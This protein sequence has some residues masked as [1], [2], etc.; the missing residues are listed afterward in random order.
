VKNSFLVK[1]R[2]FI[3]RYILF[4][5]LAVFCYLFILVAIRMN[6]TYYNEFAFGKFDLGNMVQMVW[7]TGQGRFMYLTD[8]FG[9]NMPRWG[10]SHVDPIVVLFVPVF[11][12]IPHPLTLV[13][14]QLILIVATS[15]LLY[16]LARRRL[17]TS[18]AGF[19]VA[20]SYMFYPALGF[21][22]TRTSFHGVSVSIFFFVAAFYLF[23]RMYDS[24]KF[25]K[26]G[27]T[28]FW[29]LL[30]ITM[31][32]KEQVPLYTF[33]YGLFLWLYRKKRTLGLWVSGVSLVWFVM[34]FF[35][36]IPAFS[37]YRIEGYERFAQSL[38]LGED[39][40]E[41]V[42]SS[43]YFLTRY[44]AFG[45]SYSEVLINMATRPVLV[46]KEFFKG[47]GRRDFVKTFGPVGF[48][49]FLSPGLV[50]MA[51][52]DLMI[53]YLS[54]TQGIG[55]TSRIDTHRIS[56]IIPVIFIS[57][58]Y[59]VKFL[60]DKLSS[61]QK[62]V[63][64]KV[65]AI[66]FSAVILGTSAYTT[67]VYKNTIYFWALDS[68][69]NR[70]APL[71]SARTAK[72]D[73]SFE[74]LSVGD[75]VDFQH[76]QGRDAD[77]GWK[78]VGM[79]PDNVSVSGPD[80]LGAPLSL[81][82]T[83]AI[84]PAL[85][86]EADYVIVD[87]FSNKLRTILDEDEEITKTAI[88]YLMESPDYSPVGACG[89]LFVFKRG[90][91]TSGTALEMEAPLVEVSEYEDPLD[92]DF[93][94]ELI[95]ADFTLPTMFVRE[96]PQQFQMVYYKGDSEFLGG[97][98]I[99][100]SFVNAATHD[101]FQVAHLP[102]NSYIPRTTWSTGNYYIENIS[103]ALPGYLEPGTYKVFAGITNFIRTRNI[104]LGSVEVM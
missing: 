87:V 77:C 81:R 97:F 41:N 6:I 69:R 7:N 54:S 1:I 27:L 101:L 10:M 29:V 22:V 61:I 73:D 93:Y 19:L 48:T 14:S 89:T 74:N 20:L 88:S 58:I 104:Y 9:T 51:V 66:V 86:K 44:E 13:I 31:S 16:D 63:G 33:F 26:V 60:S 103:L 64:F 65:W 67:V 94:N 17:G 99:Y 102:S 52:P 96:V 71:V 59:S 21:L 50:I 11:Y 18:L 5:G 84:F 85:Y 32:G 40:G 42:T 80:H 35:V 56:M 3:E 34:A 91:A 37:D 47:G 4:F 12:L 92:Y 98:H 39:S 62:R 76:I 43:N 100:S 70:V 68:I 8:Y 55:S 82:E 38:D 57:V 25:T 53:N 2:E 49:P 36:I 83:Y 90:M 79:I 78:I 23:E 46:Y 75:R 24:G 15:F 72:S 30:I 45:D 95:I 28:G